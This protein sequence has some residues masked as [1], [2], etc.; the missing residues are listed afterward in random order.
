MIMLSLL[1][2]F[3]VADEPA[4]PPLDPSCFAAVA[5]AV[6][7]ASEPMQIFGCRESADIPA[8]N[9]EGW[10]TYEPSDGGF[11]WGKLESVSADSVWTFRVMYNSGGAGNFEYEVTGEPD[12][13][14]IIPTPKVK[15]LGGT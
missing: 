14:G 5:W 12:M 10:V 8:P 3:A 9:A 13:N 1:A 11:V 6:D 4:T 7:P 15:A 2:A